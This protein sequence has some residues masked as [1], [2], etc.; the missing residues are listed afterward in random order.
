MIGFVPNNRFRAAIF[1]T[2]RTRSFT[3]CALRELRHRVKVHVTWTDTRTS[4]GGG[5]LGSNK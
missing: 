3:H 2:R 1:E 4:S 5:R